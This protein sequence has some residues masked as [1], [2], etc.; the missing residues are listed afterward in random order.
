MHFD[1]AS[2]CCGVAEIGEIKD[3]DE[4][5]VKILM[6]EMFDSDFNTQ[7]ECWGMGV[8]YF[9]KHVGDR[10]YRAHKTLDHMVNLGWVKGEKFKN[11]NTGN[12]IQPVTMYRSYYLKH[13]KELS[14]KKKEKQKP[15]CSQAKWNE[16]CDKMY[17]GGKLTDKE[18]HLYY[19]YND[20]VIAQENDDNY[21]YHAY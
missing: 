20:W 9:V 6:A 3:V 5:E 7:G 8:A 18:R 4:N 13:K 2:T 21:Y 1:R 10:K 12:T 14:P 15:P 16:L 11:P 17:M 19:A